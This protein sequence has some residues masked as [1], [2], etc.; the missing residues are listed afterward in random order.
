MTEVALALYVLLLSAA[1]AWRSWVQMRR[2]GSTGFKGISGRPGSGEWFGGVL[3]VVALAA[4]AAA[5]ALVLADVIETIPALD[6]QAAHMIGIAMF[7]AGMGGLLWAQGVMGNSWRVGVDTLETTDLVTGG[8][9]AVV[10]NPFF[11]ALLPA[12]L[13]LAL[14]VPAALAFAGA[15]VLL[16][17]VE[18]Q[19]RLVEEPYLQLTHGRAYAE[20]AA[21][22][23]R[24]A[25]GVGRL[26]P[27]PSDARGTVS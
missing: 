5:P 19:V 3:F 16:A 2:T 12:A 13:G 11:S 24:F 21:D 27:R 17:A 14:M 25:P 26:Q 22:V 18:L 9:F 7:A 15:V 10:R 1:F 4:G 6:A 23:G 8:P 20:Y